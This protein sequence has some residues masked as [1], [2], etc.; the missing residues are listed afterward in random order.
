MFNIHRLGI[1][2]S[3]EKQAAKRKKSRR[4]G[5]AAARTAGRDFAGELEQAAAEQFENELIADLEEFICEINSQGERLKEH[6]NRREF[7]KYKSMIR[8]FLKQVVEGSLRVRRQKVYKR[9]R[10][11]ISTELID[12]KLYRLGHYL[13]LEEAEHLN[14]AG[15]IDEIRGLL[16]DSLDT[17]KQAAAQA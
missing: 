15:D 12:E 1:T 8:R 16:Y 5:E 7:L 6:P 9:D 10:E 4:S 17:V 13:V 11:L 2:G 3:N 14:I